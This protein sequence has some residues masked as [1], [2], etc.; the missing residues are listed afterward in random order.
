M[1]FYATIHTAR[2]APAAREALNAAILEAR[3]AFA[4][5][6]HAE[7][8]VDGLRSI[9]NGSPEFAE[10]VVMRDALQRVQRSWPTDLHRA[11]DMER[12]SSDAV[13]RATDAHLTALHHVG[14]LSTVGD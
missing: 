4:A 5:V 6:F 3:A 7:R 13:T 11:T 8:A 12:A 9:A 10:L 2:D 1:P 14:E